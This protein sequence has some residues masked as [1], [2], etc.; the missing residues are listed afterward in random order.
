MFFIFK[1]MSLPQFIHEIW[2]NQ[3]FLFLIDGSINRSI[4][5]IR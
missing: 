5:L 1:F 2:F 4:D 3:I